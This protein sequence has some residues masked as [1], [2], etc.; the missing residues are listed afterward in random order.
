MSVGDNYFDG[1]SHYRF[2][3]VEKEARE[4]AASAWVGEAKSNII[5]I[6]HAEPPVPPNA[7]SADAP[8]ASVS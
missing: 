7:A 5:A 3:D 4:L 2:P 8:P 6:E 1:D